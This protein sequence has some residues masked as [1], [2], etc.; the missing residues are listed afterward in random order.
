MS[1]RR[2]QDWQARITAQADSIRRTEQS[3]H[4]FK[5]KYD[6]LAHEVVAIKAAHAKELQRASDRARTEL[7]GAVERH[8]TELAET[9]EAHAALV[10]LCSECVS[11]LVNLLF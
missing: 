4:D 5:H 3:G 2:V 11:K 7:A 10:C 6:R 9:R 1:F 8:Q